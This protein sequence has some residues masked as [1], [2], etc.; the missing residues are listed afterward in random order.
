[1]DAPTTTLSQDSGAIYEQHSVARTLVLHLLP[2]AL[3]L[4]FFVAIAPLVRS[5][6]FPLAMG[7]YVAILFVLIPFEL[8]YLIYQA[9]KNGTSFGDIVLYRQPVPKGQFVLLVGAL[10]V[11]G[12]IISPLV[13]PADFFVKE[14]LFSWLP[15]WLD[16]SNGLAKGFARFSTTAV[17]I[18]W[19]FGLIVNGIVAPVVE[20]MYFRG[21]L[22]PRISRLGAWAPVVNTVLFSLYHFFS[23]FQI[24]SRIIQFLPV[25]YAAWWKRSI[26]VSMASHVLGNVAGSVV[27]LLLILGAFGASPT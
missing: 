8:G 26:Y 17:L 13:L 23:P 15:W 24:V 14:T 5:F 6:G 4:V 7:V 1:M 16:I 22:L 18:T 3:I 20:E 10:F 12:I 25:V 21:Y 9:R 19:V 2:G 11:W 27:T